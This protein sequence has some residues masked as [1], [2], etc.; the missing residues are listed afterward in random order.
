MAGEERRQQI[1]RIAMKLFSQRGFRGTTTKEIAQAAGISEAM[2]FRHFANKEE[3]YAAI[4][5][6][7][8]CAGDMAEICESVAG[9]VA[10]GDDRAVFESFASMM[11]QHHEHD[12]EFLRL[13]LYSAL[14]GHELFEMFWNKNV[15]EMAQFLGSYIRERQKAGA[16]RELE[17]MIAGRAFSGMV[18]YHSLVTTL[19]DKSRSLLDITNERAAHEFTEIFLRGVI[20][21]AA[22]ARA[23]ETNRR[24]SNTV[25]SKK[26][27]TK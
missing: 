4:L 23:V 2:V 27:Q 25:T 22:P 1:V 18:A 11:L 7:K 16:L 14:E 13:L 10:R 3:L 5:D 9:A 26:K 8:A 24:A 21:Q 6:D 15:R 19:F 17:P 12:P 20:S